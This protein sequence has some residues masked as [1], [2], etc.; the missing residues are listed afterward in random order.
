MTF[1]LANVAGR[2]ALVDDHQRWH[3]LERVSASAFSS[4]LMAAYRHLPALHRVAATLDGST[5]DGDLASADLR[6]PVPAPRNCLAV[7]LNYRSHAAES[8]MELPAAPLVFTKFP[9]CLVGPAADVVL[10][11][12]PT[13]DYEVEL[14][15]V[16]GQGGRH[17]PADQAWQHVAGLTIGQD[18]SDRALQFAAKPPH[19][20]LGKSRDTFGPIGPFVVSTDAFANPDDLAITCD[21]N[22]ERRQDDRTSNL[23]FSVGTLIEY[24]SAVMTLAPGDLI[25]TGTPDGVGAASK[26]FLRP[27]DVIVSTIEGIGTI[28]NRCVA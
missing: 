13:G 4:D 25:F 22:G 21:I 19:F 5:P 12:I 24:I 28:S 1:R 10:E 15:V 7:G 11:G 18:I 27:G 14:V 8:G 2:A 17:I 20:D 3:D 23:V 6:A 9:S 16:I 26:R